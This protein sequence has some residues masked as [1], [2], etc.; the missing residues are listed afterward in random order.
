MPKTGL[1]LPPQCVSAPFGLVQEHVAEYP[2]QWGAI[3]SLAQKV[4]CSPESLWKRLRRTECDPGEPRHR[5]A[6]LQS[7]MN[8]TVTRSSQASLS[9]AQSARTSIVERPAFKATD[10]DSDEDAVRHDPAAPT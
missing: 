9:C 1:G 3:A 6:S 8:W 7:A 10:R 2:S 5:G 4:G